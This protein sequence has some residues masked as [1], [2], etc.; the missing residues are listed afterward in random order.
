M[1]FF[2]CFTNHLISSTASDSISPGKNVSL[3]LL[4]LRYR[5]RFFWYIS[6]KHISDFDGSIKLHQTY[7]KSNLKK[8]LISRKCIHC[9]YNFAF[10]PFFSFL[11]QFF[12]YM[13]KRK[14]SNKDASTNE[15]IGKLKNTRRHKRKTSKTRRT[16][17]S[18]TRRESYAWKNQ[19]SRKKI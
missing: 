1:L 18:R 2:P 5:V 7:L 10:L 4:F 9:L 3:H 12:F 16:K 19:N 17:T 13:S 11:L 15:D 14:Y 6:Q 8:W